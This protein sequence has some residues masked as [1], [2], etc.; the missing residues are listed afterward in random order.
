MENNI[1]CKIIRTKEKCLE[2]KVIIINYCVV[3][4]AIVYARN[5]IGSSPS[6]MKISIILVLL[7][8]FDLS[9]FISKSVVFL[10]KVTKMSLS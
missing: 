4:I 8:I 10:K 7:Y 1:F 5:T 2:K 6:V 3:I 9:K